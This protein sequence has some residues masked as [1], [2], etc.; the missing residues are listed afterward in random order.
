M[1]KI[2]NVI[3]CYQNEEEVIKYAEQLNKQSLRAKIKL[4]VVINKKGT[5]SC[6]LFEKKLQGLIEEYKIINVEKN[7][8]YL[9][10]LLI[11]AKYA[12]QEYNY[13]WLI[14]SNTDIL[15]P[16]INFF[17]KMDNRLRDFD[18]DIWAVGPSIYA[19]NQGEYSNPYMFSRPSKWEYIKINIALT[20]PEIFDYLFCLKKNLRKRKKY[21]EVESGFVYAIHG[22]FMI[23]RKQLIEIIMNRP[24]WELLYDEESYISEIVRINNKKIY[25]EKELLVKHLEGMSTGK[26]KIKWKY[27]IMKQS[28]KRI[29]KEFY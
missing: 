19:P 4:Y 11:G 24:A 21:I 10:G 18:K 3:I 26:T 12:L 7:I 1:K 14:F 25:F 16:D 15:I 22:S 9:N 8:G 13:E 23:L 6:N 28:N 29:L 2:G 5:M 20:F 17:K 27:K